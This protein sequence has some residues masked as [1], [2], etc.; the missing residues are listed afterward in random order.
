MIELKN[1]TKA[2]AMGDQVVKA[3][4]NIDLRIDDG[5]FVAIIGPSGSGKSTLMNLIGCLDTPSKGSYFLNGADVSR[6][7]SNAL[8]DARNKHIGFVF[9]R[10][11]L[12]GRVSALRNVE[13]PARYAGQ[14]AA[15]RKKNAMQ[16]L[17]SVGLADRTKHTP[18]ELS[19]GQQQRVA[20]ARALI[21]NPTI[22]LADEPTG[23]L[24]SKTGAEILA[25]FSALHRDRGMTVILVTHDPEVAGHAD[26]IIAIRDGKVASDVRGRGSAAS[27][28][29]AASE[30]AAETA[31]PVSAAPFT[32]SA[33][34]AVAPPPASA[35][36][37]E[38][39]SVVEQRAPATA[40][41]PPAKAL[42]EKV[43]FNLLVPGL[44]AVALSCA[45]NFAIRTLAVNVFGLPGFGALVAWMPPML[46]AILVTLGIGLFALLRRTAKNPLGAFKTVALIAL[47]ASFVPNVLQIVSP[48]TLAPVLTA[49]GAGGQGFGQRQRQGATA[50]NP[51][52]PNATTAADGAAPAGNGQ[53]Q[54]QGTRNR[55]AGAAGGAFNTNRLATQGVLASMHVAAYA[56]TLIVLSRSASVAQRASIK[57]ALDL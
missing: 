6:M 35:P 55:A 39:A 34:W 38:S 51:A 29:P 32:T 52:A 46:T 31:V 20:I 48:A 41:A 27:A 28:S 56:I 36:Q 54:G 44:I 50:A 14:N 5:E 40:D 47:L 25:L 16:A 15:L 3:L 42:P 43:S 21:N 11:N 2:Y 57:K 1:V 26:R 9:Q 30:N 18:V 49:V 45:V 7:R 24:D 23:A 13:M 22:L 12:L 33:P 4:D 10:F 17:T 37:P 19:G 8:A 53:A